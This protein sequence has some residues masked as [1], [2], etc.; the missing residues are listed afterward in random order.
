MK[1][2]AAKLRFTS[3]QMDQ[4][5]SSKFLRLLPL[6][7]ELSPANSFLSFV[8]ISSSKWRTSVEHVIPILKTLKMVKKKLYQRTTT[9][10]ITTP[11]DH[12]SA[13][14]LCP[15]LMI[16]S[17]AMYSIVPQKVFVVS[18]SKTDS[19]HRPKSVIL[20]FPVLSSRMFSGFRSLYTIPKVVFYERGK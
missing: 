1:N 11:T 6:Q 17:G 14:L 20:I 9:T 10:Y 13:L 19:L 2:F 5:I 3:L 4:A 16:T 8:S 12:Q 15:R 7:F 18:S